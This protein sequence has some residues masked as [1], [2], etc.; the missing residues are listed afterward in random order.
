M[1]KCEVVLCQLLRSDDVRLPTSRHRQFHSPKKSS[2][3]LFLHGC[4]HHDN[5][6]VNVLA[7]DITELNFN[8]TGIA[9]KLFEI[10]QFNKF[11]TTVKIP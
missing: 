8:T 1:A 9:F 3:R 7:G 2:N 4:C 10:I 11:H 6:K 5:E